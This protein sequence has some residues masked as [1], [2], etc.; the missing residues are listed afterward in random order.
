LEIKVAVSRRPRIAE[1]V[2]EVH[3]NEL[4]AIYLHY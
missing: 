3:K 2:E 4:Y 1:C